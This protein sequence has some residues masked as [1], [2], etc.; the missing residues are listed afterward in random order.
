[1]RSPRNPALGLLLLRL[2]LASVMIVHG[3]QKLFGAF[4]GSG[5]TGTARYFGS[6]GIP[7]PEGVVWAVSIAEFG[8][9]ILLLIGLFTSVAAAAIAVVMAGAIAIAHWPNG[10]TGEG[11]YEFPMMNLAVAVALVLTGPGRYS[12]DERP[13][14][15]DA[16]ALARR[17]RAG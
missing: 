12:L 5:L 17:K 2:A 4:G 1:M 11:G 14:M 8:G 7:A 3:A 10:F 9:G 15:S 13:G 16:E 6:L